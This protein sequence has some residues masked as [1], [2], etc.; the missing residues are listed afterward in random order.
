[1]SRSIA[2]AWRMSEGLHHFKCFLGDKVRVRP[3]LSR[4][5]DRTHAETAT[6]TIMRFLGFL[7]SFLLFLAVSAGLTIKNPLKDP[8]AP[9]G[10]D[11]TNVGIAPVRKCPPPKQ[12]DPQGNCRT[13]FGR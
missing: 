2:I 10:T 12:M 6:H 13:P 1:M 9:V 7:F 4:P 5:L 8:N 3:E 11:T